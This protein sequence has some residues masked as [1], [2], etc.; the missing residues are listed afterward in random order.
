M[1]ASLRTMLVALVLTT[2]LATA[3]FAQPPLP[4][5][6]VPALRAEPVPPPPGASY[7]W[8]PGYWHWNGSGYVWVGGRYVIRQPAWHEWIPAGWAWR[9]GAWAWVP[10]HWR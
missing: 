2:P 10:G 7:I 1:P 6:P 8:R 9:G 4:Y 5:P 3:A